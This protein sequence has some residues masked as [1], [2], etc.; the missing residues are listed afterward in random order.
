MKFFFEK[1]NNDE[2]SILICL[3]ILTPCRQR[4]SEQWV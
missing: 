3:A 1:L 2:K 4:D